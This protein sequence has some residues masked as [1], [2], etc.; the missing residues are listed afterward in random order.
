MDGTGVYRALAAENR[1][2]QFP[3]DISM[4]DVHN[5]MQVGTTNPSLVRWS[6]KEG[7]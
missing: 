3:S 7:Q 1:D 4:T 6:D 5:P 2:D